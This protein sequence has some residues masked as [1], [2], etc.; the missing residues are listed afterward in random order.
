MKE[1]SDVNN[2]AFGPQVPNELITVPNELIT[3][4]NTVNNRP[5]NKCGIPH[6]TLP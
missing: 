4:I 6:G 1:I 3:V 2:R 5:V